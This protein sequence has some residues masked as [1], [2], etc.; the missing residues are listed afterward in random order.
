VD[1]IQTTD[2]IVYIEEGRCRG[3]VAACLSFGAVARANRILRVVVDPRARGDRLIGLIGHELQHAVEV[4]GT[5][6]VTS[7]TH[8]YF[9][10]L[11]EGRR[12]GLSGSSI[13]ETDAAIETGHAIRAEVRQDARLSTRRAPPAAPDPG[14]IVVTRPE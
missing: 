14:V 5:P 9:F 1:T 12:P 13:F 3:R 7:S 11:R 6:A 2:G 4:L 10:Y 8:M